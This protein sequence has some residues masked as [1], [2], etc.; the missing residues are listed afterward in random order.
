M[1]HCLSHSSRIHVLIGENYDFVWCVDREPSD[2][3][4]QQRMEDMEPAGSRRRTAD[5][6]D[7]VLESQEQLSAASQDQG[8][9][10]SHRD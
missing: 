4:R 7:T 8:T 3:H 10:T 5:S 2:D 1:H 6:D 9:E